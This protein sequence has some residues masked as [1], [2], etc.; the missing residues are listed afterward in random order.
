MLKNLRLQLLPNTAE[1]LRWANDGCL[2]VLAGE[3]VVILVR[4]LHRRRRLR[5]GSR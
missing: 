3:D 4:S 1:C 2:A 5:T